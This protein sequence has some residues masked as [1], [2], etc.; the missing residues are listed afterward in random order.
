MKNYSFVLL[1]TAC[2]SPRL[3]EDNICKLA[4]NDSQLRLHDY[5]KA[6]RYWLN[7]KDRKIKG[8]IFVENSGYDLSALIA[9]S[10][11]NPFDRAVE[12]VQYPSGEIPLGIH[13]GYAELDMID[14]V[15]LDSKI[16]GSFDFVIKLTGRLIFPNL[17]ELINRIDSKY[18]FMIDSK[19]YLFGKVKQRYCVTTL[20]VMRLDFYNKYL[21]NSKKLLTPQS[22]YIEHLFYRIIKPLFNEQHNRVCMRFP[23]SVPPQGIGGHSNI[24]YSSYSF[25]YKELLRSI[26]RFLLPNLW[27]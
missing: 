17:E 8:I 12:F 7:Y 27:I 15:I 22:P 25:K 26:F 23:I 4:R 13:Y 18:N 5:I 14:K 19:N 11:N 24:N 10:K 21:Y 1:L 3:K 16:I 2:I 9:E 6:L 20:F